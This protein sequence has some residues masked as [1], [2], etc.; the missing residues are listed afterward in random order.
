M[1]QLGELLAGS[2]AQAPVV[3]SVGEEEFTAI[4]HD[5][6]NVVG[7]E[8]FVAIRTAT[9]DGHSFIGEAFAR[10]ATGFLVDRPIEGL[11]P[12]SEAGWGGRPPT[13]VRVASCREALVEWAA[14]RLE[15]TELVVVGGSL[16]KSTA[17]A[18]IRAAWA[19]EC[20][21]QV[22]GN[23]DRNDSLGIPIALASGPLHP[24]RAV[25]EVA[26]ADGRE[27]RL[28]ARMLN[29]RVVCVT[30]TVDAGALYW[31]SPAA[32][33]DQMG[34]LLPGGAT[35]VLPVSDS[36]LQ[37]RFKE[38]LQ[39]TFGGLGSGATVQV[40]P[41]DMEGRWPG[42]WRCL[43]LIGKGRWE[44]PA[45]LHPVVGPP[46]WGA[47]LASLLA[48]KIEPAAALEA[49]SELE[50]LPGRLS[51]L[52][53]AA[54]GVVLDDS[55]VDA[56]P[57][58]M[59]L[60]QQALRA[61]PG[62]RM[63]VVSGERS[64]PGSW[65]AVRLVVLD[66]HSSG[67]SG[68]GH[69][70]ATT[71]ASFGEAQALAVPLLAAGGTV[72]VKGTAAQRLERLSARLAAPGSPLVRQDRGRRLLGFR[73]AQRPTW[74]EVDVAAL[75]A[76][77]AEVVSEL[78]PV[79]LMAVV[80]ADAYG[81]GAVQVARTALASGAEWVATATLAEAGQL[82]GAGI[83]APCLVLGYTPPSQ[84]GQALELGVV[85]TVFDQEVLGALEAAGERAGRVARAHLKVDT[86]M[87]RLGIPPAEVGAFVAQA[88]GLLHVDLE[89]IYTHFRMGQDVASA[90]Q[91]LT[92]LL[93]SV[94]AAEARGHRFRIRHAASSAA[95]RHLPA[96]RLDLV[97]CGGELLGLRTAD[98]R[99]RLPVLSFKT[100]VAQIHDLEADTYV[101][102]G[103]A[104]RA[105]RAMRV[106]TISVGYGDGFRRGPANWAAVLIR[107]RLHRLVGDVSMDMAMVDISGDSAVS[108]GDPVVLIG[109]DGDLEITAEDVAARLGTINY[110]VVTQILARVPREVAG[111]G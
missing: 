104:F 49:L 81:H 105:E 28:L 10:G 14:K 45:R 46:A 100:T 43:V 94:K 33:A 61:L 54:G 41:Q 86:G 5:S 66:E 102:Y 58:S 23:G 29:P 8:F 89:G 75:A 69:R 62:P 18:A 74:V 91:Q 15:G 71:V 59:A 3:I 25:L 22:V 42:R 44:L 109:R 37:R 51:L 80:K 4:A 26:A 17:Q 88:Q 96:A 82:R 1:F 60:A 110:E 31:R 101:G 108:R 68:R 20:G 39:V 48:L 97:R 98:G 27:E 79:P 36:V 50:P 107:G 67:S 70:R 30:T 56:T 73:S 53:G 76:N 21:Q 47:A 63:A 103:D 9:G 13:V 6:R 99:R 38:H 40:G 93:A 85:V 77:V 12:W 90:E 55:A 84:I 83:D 34:A 78:A 106:A 87:S 65:D 7:G 111:F 19:A 92:R 32:L 16:G 64:W 57:Q 72:L 2:A 11:A 52:R 95:W 35:L 24:S